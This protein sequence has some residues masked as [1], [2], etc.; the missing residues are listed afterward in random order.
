MLRVF[1]IL[2]LVFKAALV[3]AD[4]LQT[5]SGPV[6]IAPMVEGLDAP[7]AIGILP[8]KGFLVTE[9]EGALLYVA[10]GKAIAV[11]GVPD[12][13]AKGQGGLLDVTVARDFNQTREIFLT[14]SKPQKGGAGT[15]LAVGRLSERGDR[16]TNLRVIFEAVPGGSSGRHYGSRVVEAK[17]GTL[18]VTIGDRG[19]RPKAQD[20]SNHNGTVIRVNRDGSVPGDNPFVQESGARPEIWSYGHRNPQGA[21]LDARGRLWISEHGAKGGDEVN[22]VQRGSNYGWPVISYGVHYSGDK[23]GEGTAKPGMEQPEYYWD[24][25]IAPSGLMVYS[26]KLWPDWKGDIFVGSLKFDYIARMA[27]SPL[28]EVEQIKGPETIRVRD[29]VEAHD[30]S[31]WYIS[32]GDGAVYRLT[33]A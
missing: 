20:R 5:S 31:I 10:D 19:E 24:P 7:W 17:D 13:L 12:V 25:S 11:K 8:D 22:L 2:F 3:S 28:R 33:P 32:V 27:G 4:F 16:L 9:R 18:L 6:Q 26:G 23:I 30:G 14:F 1:A 29:I 15:A 21:G